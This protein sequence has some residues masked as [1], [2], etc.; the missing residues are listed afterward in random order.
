MRYRRR[1]ES[2]PQL[3]W[4]S[5]HTPSP[6]YRSMVP[7]NPAGQGFCA[8]VSDGVSGQS[9]SGRH[10]LRTARET[11]SLKER[12]PT[13]VAI[14]DVGPL[15]GGVAGS[16]HVSGVAGGA[17][18]HQ[19]VRRMHGLRPQ[20]VRRTR[21]H[22][23]PSPLFSLSPTAA[24]LIH[25]APASVAQARSIAISRESRRARQ[26]RGLARAGGRPSLELH[27]PRRV[28]SSRPP[29]SLTAMRRVHRAPFSRR[30]ALAPNVPKPDLAGLQRRQSRVDPIPSVLGLAPQLH[31]ALLSSLSHPYRTSH[32]RSV[33]RSDSRSNT[34]SAFPQFP[35]RTEVPG[36]C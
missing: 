11:M 36:S 28:Y 2:A 10:C 21:Q 13:A 7:L 15:S 17:G 33:P 34:A 25:R 12:R 32:P 30:V 16:V 14:V 3:Y 35:R 5:P 9:L 19:I 1:S 8:V 20:P 24:R 6:Q 23:Y 27:A 18:N 29:R 31:C 4:I 26:R 22:A